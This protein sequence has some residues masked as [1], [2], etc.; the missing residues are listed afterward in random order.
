MGIIGCGVI[1]QHHVEATAHCGDASLVAVADLD[2]D[3]ADHVG[4]THGVGKVYR[5]GS[6]LIR[7]PAIDAVILAVPTGLRAREA[8]R[9]LRAGKHLLLEKPPAM[10]ASQIRTYARLQEDA[11]VGF[12]SSRFTFTDGAR[13]ARECVERGDIGSLRVVRCRGIF[14]VT[15]RTPGHCPPAWRVRNSL[16]GGGF[17]VNWGIYDLDY[18]MHITGWRLQPES[19]F[20]QTWP[21]AS[22]F[23]EGRVHPDSDA[24]TH[25]VLMIRCTCGAVLVLERG[26]AVAMQDES[27]WQIS[28]DRGSLHLQ[29]ILRKGVPAVQLDQSDPDGGVTST[30][31]FQGPG[32][33][34]VNTMPVLDFVEAVREGRS[35]RTDLRKALVLQKILDAAYKSARTGKA[36]RIRDEKSE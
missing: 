30:T 1:G 12:C 20:A 32:E 19:V 21:I 3:K 22:G 11:V 31:I 13:A 35:P 28:G 14:G 29:M 5:S 23:A 2:R 15:P 24:E 18:V 8:N 10:N 27:A 34:R 16:N 17:L 7:D 4:E 9:A 36:V 33:D 26:E 25:V 6:A